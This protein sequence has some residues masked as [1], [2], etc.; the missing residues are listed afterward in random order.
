MLGP[1]KSRCLD[2]PITVSIE[3]LVP[4]NHFYRHLEVKLDLGSVRE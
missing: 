3:D 4:P 2:A 1:A